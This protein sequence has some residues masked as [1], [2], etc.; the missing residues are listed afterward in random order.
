MQTHFTY[1]KKMIPLT[2]AGGFALLFSSCGVH[3]NGLSDT[4][5][6]YQSETE[7]IVQADNEK[8]NYYKQ[9]F[10]S[11]DKTYEDLP[12]E[13]L[14]FT[15]IEAYS[16]TESLDEE[17]YIIVEEKYDDDEGYAGWGN[18]SEDVSIN[19]YNYGGYSGHFYNPFWYNYWFRPHWSMGFYWGYPFYSYYGWGYPYYYYGGYYGYYGHY[20]NPYYWHPNSH[21]PISYNRGRRNT[22]Y[23]VGRS[24]NRGRINTENARRSYTRSERL[25]RSETTRNNSTIT[26]PRSQYNNSIRNTRTIRPNNTLRNNR[27]QN[28]NN[29]VRN[30]NSLRNNN[31][32]RNNNNI[33]RPSNSSRS[34]GTMRSSGSSSRS[35]GSSRSSSGRRGGGRN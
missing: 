6:I 19:I 10:K 8:A 1:I 5:G 30:N 7:T 11:K 18:N 20:Y 4:D 3:N 14:I 26:R 24:V 12:E 35:S 32:T 29:R 15:D 34:S 2:I 22:D 23:N 25:R 33:S 31:S 27:A 13:D 28:P 9:Y 21:N 16:T 17:G